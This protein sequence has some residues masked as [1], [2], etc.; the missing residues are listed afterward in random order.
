MLYC[1]EIQ[2]ERVKIETLHLPSISTVK[3]DTHEIIS[4]D[5]RSRHT[6]CYTVIEQTAVSSPKFSEPSSPVLVDIW[7]PDLSRVLIHNQQWNLNK[8]IQDRES[9]MNTNAARETLRRIFRQASD[10]PREKGPYVHI[11]NSVTLRGFNG[12]T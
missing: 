4:S 5:R 2:E 11:R 1:P 8:E 9:E 3:E 6:L 10:N 7:S 12:V